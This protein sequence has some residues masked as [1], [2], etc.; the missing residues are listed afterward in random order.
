MRTVTGG[1]AGLEHRLWGR[2]WSYLRRDLRIW[3]NDSLWIS[4]ARLWLLRNGR[5]RET[6]SEGAW[7][8]A[9]LIASSEQVRIDKDVAISEAVIELLDQQQRTRWKSKA[10]YQFSYGVDFFSAPLVDH[11]AICFALILAN[12]AFLKGCN[13]ARRDVLWGRPRQSRRGTR[14]C[15]STRLEKH[16]QEIATI[17]RKL[18]GT[19]DAIGQRIV[20][21]YSVYRDSKRNFTFPLLAL[22]GA[23]WAHGYFRILAAVLPWYA[24]L[25]FP[26]RWRKRAQFK[27]S[28]SRAIAGFKLANKRVLEDTYANYHFTKVFWQTS[29][30]SDGTGRAAA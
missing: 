28:V 29:W 13:E 3:K 15:H 21:H 30:C 27:A 6:A 24:T 17:A 14:S 22:H 26:V 10:S 16:R 11:I 1:L 18:S 25:R 2:L 20:C 7:M 8:M 23:G 5:R 19:D 9:G 12:C 4:R